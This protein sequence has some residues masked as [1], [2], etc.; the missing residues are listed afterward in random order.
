[1]PHAISGGGRDEGAGYKVKEE[2][3][4]ALVVSDVQ[5]I[6]KKIEVPVY[7]L[8]DVPKEQVKYVTKEEPQV[9]YITKE[10]DTTRYKVEEKDT[11]KF[12]VR[13]EETVKYIPKEI[14]VERPVA[15]PVEYERPVVK[16][17]IIEVVNYGDVVALKQFVD[18]VVDLQK[19]LEGLK[20][21]INKI[22]GY[23]LV[24]EVIKAPKIEWVPTQVE[25]I[26]W[27]DVERER[28]K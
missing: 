12:R 21:S 1:M 14:Q 4:K 10:L 20:E 7:K 8:V 9:K 15:V 28:P 22:K 6:E 11:V 19:E 25:R 24:E 3:I 27:K 18:V 5:I 13:E 26:V 2:K 23:K 17:K 16:E